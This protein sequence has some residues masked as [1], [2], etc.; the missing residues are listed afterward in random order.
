MNAQKL[1]KALRSNNGKLYYELQLDLKQKNPQLLLRVLEYM[2]NRQLP[3][4]TTLINGRDLLCWACYYN[5]LAALQLILQQ[6]QTLENA[7]VIKLLEIVTVWYDTN[8]NKNLLNKKEYHTQSEKLVI[9]LFDH[10]QTT[11][12]ISGELTSVLVVACKFYSLQTTRRIIQAAHTVNGLCAYTG[13]YPI[14][15]AAQRPNG[16]QLI[17]LLIENG[18]ELLNEQIASALNMALRFRLL[19]NMQVL[20]QQGAYFN[21]P[22]YLTLAAEIAP[23]LI[24]LMVWSIETN[25]AAWAWAHKTPLQIKYLLPEPIVKAARRNLLS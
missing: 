18:A 24:P 17:K 9:A 4:A 8:N 1:N 6:T 21:A 3:I 23:N 7:H 16:Q 22:T 11:K 2:R 10:Q 15:Q 13:Y 19:D 25:R 12:P 20:L 5:N 14:Q